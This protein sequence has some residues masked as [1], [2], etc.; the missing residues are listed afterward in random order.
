MAKSAAIRFLDMTWKWAN[1]ETP[2]SWERLNHAMHGALKLAIGAGFPFGKNDIAYIHSNYNS[3][4]WLGDSDEWIYSDAILAG[5]ASCFKSYEL[6]YGREPIIADD[7]SFS[8]NSAYL[9]GGSGR[10]KERLAVGF[11]FPWKGYK[12]TVTSFNDEKKSLTACSY[13]KTDSGYHRKVEKRFTI[14]R[15][16]ILAER[17]ERKERADIEKQLVDYQQQNGLNDLV[18]ALGV[19]SKEEFDRL[20]M[21]KLRKRAK[22]ILG[23]QS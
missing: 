6:H 15:D 17:A 19:S 20:P 4:F 23:E 1:S 10:A 12:V 7:V 11:S 8:P 14:T 21:S 16:D 22:A 18:D 3:G 9:H 13:K 2:H 5:N